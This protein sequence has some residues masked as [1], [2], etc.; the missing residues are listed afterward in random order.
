[1]RKLL[2]GATVAVSLLI[3]EVAQARPTVG[4][5]LKSEYHTVV[6][7]NDSKRLWY[8]RVRLHLGRCDARSMDELWWETY[9]FKVRPGRTWKH[10]DTKSCFYKDSTWNAHT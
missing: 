9:R 2:V 5:R 6:C 7:W 8:F 1:M 10:T 4:C 3:P